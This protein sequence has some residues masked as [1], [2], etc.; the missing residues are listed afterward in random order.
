M[1]SQSRPYVAMAV[2]YNKTIQGKHDNSIPCRNIFCSL[3]HFLF[4]GTILV[5]F[6]AFLE[7]DSTPA[8]TWTRT[9]PKKL[10][11]GPL[12]V[13]RGH[14][15]LFWQIFRRA[16]TYIEGLLNLLKWQA[17]PYRPHTTLKNTRNLKSVW[18]VKLHEFKF[19]LKFGKDEQQQEMTSIQMIIYF[20][21]D[22]EQD[23]IFLAFYNVVCDL[24]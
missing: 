8:R 18:R 4:P 6:R 14:I 23:L 19:I 7:L 21:N 1:L 10:L 17:N 11:L 20:S 3:P 24:L 12:S 2:K 22:R 15:G 13:A 9:R 5:R 16:F